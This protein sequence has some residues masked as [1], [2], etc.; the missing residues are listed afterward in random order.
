MI[1]RQE[2]QLK[3]TTVSIVFSIIVSASFL[4]TA[5]AAG[6]LSRLVR[7]K[8]SAGD[9]LSGVAAVEDYKRKNGVDVEYLDALG[10]LARG[11]EM[12]KQPDAAAEFVAELRR[13]IREEK[14]DPLAGSRIGNRG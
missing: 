10:W 1:A 4:A 6:E 9:L 13:E 7:L 12:L 2:V 3:K 5:L 11:A 8:V 14:P